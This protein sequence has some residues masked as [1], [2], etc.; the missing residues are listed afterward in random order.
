MDIWGD[1]H[2]A[3]GFFVNDLLKIDKEAALLV[4][5]KDV[6]DELDILASL[7][8]QQR[9]V[10][11]DLDATLRDFKNMSQSD[12]FDL[13][14]KVGEQQRLV[15]LDIS[16]LGRVARQA[17]SVNDNLTQVLVLKQKHANVVEGEAQRKQAEEAVRQ[18][19]TIMVFT[20]VTI[21]FLPLSF[22]SSFFAI[23]II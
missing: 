9:Q 20:V 22:L 1:R 19:Q 17:R 12:Q 13:Y 11:G 18:R 23:D 3:S 7:L 4:E 2:K 5:C 16:D 8:R 10:L 14:N 21:V 15:V 6:D